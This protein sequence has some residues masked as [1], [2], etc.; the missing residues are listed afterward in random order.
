MSI[1]YKCK[2]VRQAKNGL[3]FFFRKQA[4]VCNHDFNMFGNTENGFNLFTWTQDI[5]NPVFSTKGKTIEH[6]LCMEKN[7]LPDCVAGE[8]EAKSG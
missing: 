6:L 3:W 5:H 8:D 2:L 7:Y 4:T 1:Y